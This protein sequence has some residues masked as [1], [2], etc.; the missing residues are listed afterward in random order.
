M[1]MFMNGIEWFI[2]LGSTV[3]LPVIIFVIGLFFGLKPSKAFI[4]GITVGI[5]NI[6]LGL[7]LDLLSS[8]LGNA[9]QQMGEKYGTS[10]NVLDIGVGVGGPLAYSTSLG[11]LMI[12]ISLILN[13]I[14]VI[15]GLTKTLNVDIWNFWFPIFLGMLVQTVTGNF[16]FGLIGAIVAVMLQ[17]FLADAAQKEV[18]EFFGYPGIAITH[19]MALSGVLFAKPLNWVFDRI[20]GFNKIDADAESLTKK[21]GVFGDT[22]V[23][24]LL[25]GI[26]VG[27]LAGYDAAGIGTLGM[28]TAAVMKVMPK[29][30]AMFMEG[31]LPIAEAAKEFTDKK[32]NGRVVNI[33]MDAALT[34]GHPT[35]MSTSLLLVPISLLLAV[36]LPGNQVLPFGDLAFFTF[37]ICLMIP[38][39][40]G[41]I[42]RSLVGCSLYLVMTFYMSTWLAPIVTDVFKLANF[43]VGT[44]GMVTMLLSGLWPAGLFVLLAEKVGVIGIIGFGAIVLAGMVYN[45]KIKKNKIVTT[46]AA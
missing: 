10:L 15:L 44:S 43:D 42:V 7:V 16:W 35:V 30:V 27:I 23:I 18:S 26:V 20:P 21:F 3:F 25:I 32:L 36:I 6:G 12:P 2:G 14:L 38:F 17:W 13:F 46:E 37:A 5:G 40:K 8:G 41:N 22:V 39:F 4:S 45:N 31:L 1:D 11:I 28:T 19:M 24:G 9:I 34:V 29:M 33:G